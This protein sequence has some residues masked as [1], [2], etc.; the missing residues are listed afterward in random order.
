MSIIPG[1]KQMK[2]SILAAIGR[3][4]MDETRIITAK[5]PLV[6]F[7]SMDGQTLDEIKSLQDTN[8]CPGTVP[9]Y[10]YETG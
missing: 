7:G 2:C 5:H 8:K 6:V 3:R 4:K 1:G 9:V 10:L